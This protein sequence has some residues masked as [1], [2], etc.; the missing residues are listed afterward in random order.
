[1]PRISFFRSKE[2]S[3]VLPHGIHRLY[4]PTPNGDLEILSAQPSNPHASPGRRK[5]PIFFAHGGCGSAAVWLEYM[6]FFSQ[7]YDI[8]CYAVSYRGHGDSWYPS[9][10]RMYFTGKRAFAE[11]LVAAVKYVQTIEAGKPERHHHKPDLVLVGH[12]SGGALVQEVLG[13]GMGNLW[14]KGMVLMGSIPC[15]GK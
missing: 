3:L 6:E 8:P 2:P 5:T 10:W 7:Q 4:C 1:M 12:S 9:Y 13:E 15:F 14:I 11:D